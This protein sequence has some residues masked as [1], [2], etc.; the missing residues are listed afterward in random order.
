M[1]PDTTRTDQKYTPKALVRAVK[2]EGLARPPFWLM[3]QAGR[4]LPEYRALRRQAD[5][6][7]AFC[8][9]ADLATTAT[10]QP[11]ARFPVDAAIL[12]SDILVVPDALG[13]AV[14]F[15]EGDGPR[16]VPIRSR[17]Q[18]TALS[19]DGLVEYLSPVYETVSRVSRQLSDD[20]ALIGFAG[21]PW[22]V[23]TYMV[24]GGSSKDFVETKSWAYRDPDGF[25]ALI[26]LLI[27]ATARHL[28]AQIRH[29]AE[30]V[31]IFDSWA[32]VLPTKMFER[33]CIAPSR[34]VV[35]RVRAAAPEVPVI[36]FPRGA[37]PN[38]ISYAL[39]SGV[40][41]VGLDTTIP[42]EWAAAEIQPHCAVQ[43]NL[44]PILLRAGGATMVSAIEE[45]LA[46]LGKGPFVFNLGHGVVPTTPVENVA[47]LADTVTNWKAP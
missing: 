17:D 36:G 15:K 46:T 47:L 33:W 5:G 29:G 37:G 8:Y 42:L 14:S 10:L 40:D 44:D 23:A 9:T 39:K 1:K 38:I 13:A 45:I 26:E 31:Q 34:A 3:R 11:I 27:E 25:S 20:V 30:V 32:G 41:A 21:A 6:F 43:G 28:I 35:A 2:G 4:Y 22:T 18:L 24:E 16:V 19:L 12:F 7:L